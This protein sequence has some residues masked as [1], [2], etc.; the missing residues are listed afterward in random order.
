MLHRQAQRV[1]IPAEPLHQ[2]RRPLGVVG[3]QA[4]APATVGEAEGS[5]RAVEPARA[6][7]RGGQ[8]DLQHDSGAFGRGRGRDVGSRAARERRT[9]GDVPAPFQLRDYSGQLAHPLR[10]DLAVRRGRLENELGK[11][12]VTGHDEMDDR[13]DPGDLMDTFPRALGASGIEVS[14]LALGSWRTFERLTHPEGLAVMHAA[15]DAGI[16]FLDDARYNDETGSAPIPTGYSE[17][18][19]GELFRDAGWP[20]AETVVANKLWWE[21]WPDQSAA[22]ELDGSLARMQFDY[23]DVV[24]ANAPINGLGVEEL[25][26]SVAGL[27]TS[28]KARAWA[29]VNWPAD[30]LLEASRIAARERLPQPCAAQL[31]YSLVQR[32]PVEDPA[33][34]AALDACGAPVVA[35]FVLAGGVLTGKYDHDPNAGRAAGNLEHPLMS[36]AAVAARQL[37]ALARELDT[38]P[39]ALAVAFTLANPRVATVLF[40]A[41]RPDQ[42]RQNADAL[43]LAARLDD[44][45][46]GALRAIN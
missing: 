12:E 39:A 21:F 40:G 43:A 19:F 33:M 30:L 32:S 29:I 20:R 18:L 37:G 6:V 24:Y 1:E 2:E 15:R 17:V 36:N 9:H 10:T 42:V 41:T 16:T 44:A 35:S 45:Q 11:N 8:R 27:I 7:G 14:R 46:L 38:T 23:V 4:R 31:P 13:F 22:D 28:G 34:L 26:A 3:H 25:V 5:H